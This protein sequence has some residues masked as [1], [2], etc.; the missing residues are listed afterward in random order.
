MSKFH[1]K[2]KLFRFVKLAIIVGT[3]PDK[4]L[5]DIFKYITEVRLRISAGR[6]PDNILLFKSTY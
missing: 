6:G 3:V 4:E 1:E 5:T 2:L